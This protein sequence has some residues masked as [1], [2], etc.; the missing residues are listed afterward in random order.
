MKSNNILGVSEVNPPTSLAGLMKVVVTIKVVTAL[1]ATLE[2]GVTYLVGAQSTVTLS[3]LNGGLQQTYQ[4]N[5]NIITPST[6]DTLTIRFN[7]VSANVYDYKY[8]YAGST[9]QVS[10]AA[11]SIMAICPASGSNSLTRFK[12]NIDAYTGVNRTVLGEFTV[13]NASQITVNNSGITAGVWRDNSTNI[14]SIVIGYASISGGFG[15]GTTI[16]LFALQS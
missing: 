4:L 6:G 10:A 12:V 14:T 5:A 3:G 9:S 8:S 7:G 13:I 11:Q 15:V 16:R 2:P 1:P